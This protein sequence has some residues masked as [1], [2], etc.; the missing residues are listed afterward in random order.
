MGRGGGSERGGERASGRKADGVIQSS[1]EKKREKPGWSQR[2]RSTTVVASPLVSA[3]GM[4]P[5]TRESRRWSVGFMLRGRAGV[6]TA[7]L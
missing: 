1:L 5:K 7:R 3:R 6:I 4:K 2:L